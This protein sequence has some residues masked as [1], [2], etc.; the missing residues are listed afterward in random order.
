MASSA[1]VPSK[2]P[3]YRVLVAGGHAPHDVME[4]V[5]P[6]AVEIPS[7]LGRTL[8]HV[9]HVAVVLG[10]NEDLPWRCLAQAVDQFVDDVAVAVVDERVRRIEAEAVDVK[11]AQ[12][13]ERVVEDEA[14]HQRGAGPVEVHGA[15]PRVRVPVGQVVIA[16]VGDVRAFGAEVVVDR[17]EN[18][19]QAV[20]VCRI[21]ERAEIVWSA[22][23]ARRREE[24]HPVVSPVPVA[25][26]VSDRHHFDRRDAEVA[27]V[28]EPLA[29]GGEGA[30]RRERA[31]VQLVED[32]VFRTA[33]LPARI[34]PAIRLGVDDL[35]WT[36]HPLRLEARGRVRARLAAVPGESVE[37]PGR[38]AA[39]PGLE[40]TAIGTGQRDAGRRPCRSSRRSV[41][42]VAPGDQRRKRTPSC[43][44]TAPKNAWSVI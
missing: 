22:V 11:L 37:I 6:H 43:E 21:H 30:L 36:V 15:S 10:V 20:A 39:H 27:Q 28:R 41:I 3:K 7:A 31:D 23:G 1:A 9:R 16:E 44:G 35:R 4:V 24:R 40:H 38:G 17:V 12:P 8:Q 13:V 32:Q 26:E 18:D 34:V 5:G 14:T 19:R 42:S 2:S 33:W 25:G 29:R